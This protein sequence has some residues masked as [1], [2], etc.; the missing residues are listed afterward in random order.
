MSLQRRPQKQLKRKALLTC[1]F[2]QGAAVRA[3]TSSAVRKDLSVIMV[4]GFSELSIFP[5]G[6]A[7]ISSLRTALLMM[8]SN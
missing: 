1:S 4:L 5:M 7:S 3:R 2:P 8:A 6:L